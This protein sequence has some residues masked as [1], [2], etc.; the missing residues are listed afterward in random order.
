M[1]NAWFDA[2]IY[3]RQVGVKWVADGAKSVKISDLEG[4]LKHPNSEIQR[5]AAY[6]LVNMGSESGIHL[7]RPDLYA[8]D[9]YT[10]EKAR[11]GL[12]CICRE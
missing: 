8:N 3:D 11:D 12:L 9:V 6:A 1:I 2:I 5:S 7:I 4:L 10:R